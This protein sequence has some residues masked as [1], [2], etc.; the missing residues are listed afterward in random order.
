[1]LKPAIIVELGLLKHDHLEKAVKVLTA[2]GV[3]RIRLFISKKIQRKWGGKR[4]HERLQRLM[5]SSAEQS[6]QFA[7]PVLL[8]PVQFDQICK[9]EGDSIKIFCE[10]TGKSLIQLI[11]AQKKLQKITILIG[12]EGDLTPEEKQQLKKS[13][14]IFCR[15]TQTILR[16]ELAATLAVGIIRSG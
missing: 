9:T 4:E 1:L 15:L 6:K 7:L 16:S 3:G 12:P 2:L 10:P 13:D 14:Y 8:P 11:C 5:I